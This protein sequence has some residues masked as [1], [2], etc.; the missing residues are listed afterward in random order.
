MSSIAEVIP[1]ITFGMIVFNGQPFLR[2]NLRALY[3]FANEII[4]VEGAALGAAHHATPQG[5][6]SDGTLEVLKDFIRLE[7]PAGKVTVVTAEDEGSPD[8]FW[9]GREDRAEQGVRSQGNR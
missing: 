4:V 8:G 1:R 2:Y 9:P 7:D 3:P 5:H 6:S